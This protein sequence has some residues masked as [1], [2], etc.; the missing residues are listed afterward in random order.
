MAVY[1]FNFSSAKAETTS[2]TS[3]ANHNS[4]LQVHL[5]TY[6]QKEKKK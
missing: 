4:D 1:I 5:E 3:Q 6:A 2:Q